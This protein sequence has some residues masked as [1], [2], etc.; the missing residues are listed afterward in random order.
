MWKVT[1]ACVVVLVG[2]ALAT[3]NLDLWDGAK[4]GDLAKVQEALDAGANPDWQNEDTYGTTAIMQATKGGHL[5]AV[6]TLIDAHVNL[7]VS[8]NTGNTALHIAARYNETDIARVL[9]Q[10]GADKTTQNNNGDTPGDDARQ[11][12]N[13]DL[14][15]IIDNYVSTTTQ[16]PAT[17]LPTTSNNSTV[18]PITQSPST[19]VP[20][21]TQSP[22]TTVPTTTQSPATTVPTTSNNSTVSPI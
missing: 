20:T 6:E 4:D 12:G 22:A 11:E 15:E 8:D 19:T 7:T 5:S 9:L 10:V 17:T 1:V 21:T 3:S 14:G 16:S 2:A 18:S 13:P